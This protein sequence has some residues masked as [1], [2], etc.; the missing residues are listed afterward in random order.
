MHAAA[1]AP[2][3]RGVRP[4]GALNILMAVV[5][6]LLWAACAPFREAPPHAPPPPPDVEFPV[7]DEPAPPLS[8][9][10]YVIEGD[11]DYLYHDAHGNRLQADEVALEKAR[12]A[13]QAAVH[14]EVF[15]LHQ[16]TGFMRKL[17]GGRAG[18]LE[19]YR[20]G[21]LVSR[22][23]YTRA[24][25]GLTGD[26]AQLRAHHA[27]VSAPT[28]VSPPLTLAYFG[29]EIRAGDSGTSELSITEFARGL[30]RIATALGS[31][32]DQPYAVIVLSTCYGGTPDMMRALAPLA[33]FVVASPAYLHLSYLEAGLLATYPWPT[34][35]DDAALPVRRHDEARRLADSIA[36]V[37]FER[38]RQRTS[39]EITVAVYDL[40]T[41]VP[42]AFPSVTYTE[43]A[44]VLRRDAW[45]DC[46][47]LHDARRD[48]DIN[49][50]ITLHYQPPRFGPG[51]HV[52]TRSGWQCLLQGT[53]G[54]E[55]LPPPHAST[56]PC[57]PTS[58]DAR[59]RDAAPR[60]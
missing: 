24:T 51:K 9:T 15:I 23:R 60:W 53:R 30:E 35:T 14:G 19:H 20:A 26:V 29:H 31:D 8:R 47:N 45:G 38:L 11:A 12:E 1:L 36:A 4:R 39:T 28:A 42:P 3:C 10:I 40:D 58:P 50:G 52:I 22:T 46:L 18:R 56:S 43:E 41:L 13:A 55:V 57:S 32:A 16:H 34:P 17:W 21:H 48:G 54:R 49:R 25:P 44:P 7:P 33:E 6:V 5:T 37:S 2:C 27:P 59:C